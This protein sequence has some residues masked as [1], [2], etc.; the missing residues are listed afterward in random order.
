MDIEQ[1]YDADPRRRA[2]DEVEF[3]RDWSD[4]SGVR[5]ELSWIADTG[6]LYVMREPDAPIDMDPVGDEVVE[7]LE[8]K[9]LTV[10]V[11]GTFEGRESVDALLEGWE[12]EMRKRNSLDW[13]RARVARAGS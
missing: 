6:E 9:Q 3:G 5:S 7:N 4:G 12:D 8:T 2:S 11:L 13:V 10:E 1:F